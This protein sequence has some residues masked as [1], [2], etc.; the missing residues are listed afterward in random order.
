MDN[1]IERRYVDISIRAAG[2]AKR[3][4]IEGDAAV[5]DTETV[6]GRWFREV[7]RPGAFTRVLSEQ[8]DV[9]GA[10]NHDWNYV[11]GRTTAG[12]LRLKETDAALRY[13]IDINPADPQ[14]MS[15]YEKIKRGDVTQASFAFTVRSEKWTEPPSDSAQ[16]LALREV[17]EVDRLYDVGP[18]P[19]GA[20]PEASAQARSKGEALLSQQ[21]QATSDGVEAVARKLRAALRRVDFAARSIY[22]NPKE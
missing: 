16:I 7:I 9:I 21:P 19:F 12:T 3:P 6:I 13:E 4:I 18:V 15:V 10:Y 20:Y 14:A 8:P 2:D 11:L 22:S 1:I 5:F 17:L